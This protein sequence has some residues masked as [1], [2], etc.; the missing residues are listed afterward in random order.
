[1]FDLK[2]FIWDAEFKHWKKI[3]SISDDSFNV[4]IDEVG[5]E[6]S[7]EEIEIIKLAYRL[8]KLKAEF[9]KKYV[10]KELIDLYNESWNEDEKKLSREDF[11]KAIKIESIYLNLDGKIEVYINDNDL[12][13]GKVIFAEIDEEGNFC[14]LD[15]Q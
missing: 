2:D 6:I 11:E 15:L 1:M 4:L 3:E 5:K 14:K 12:F 9:I 13:Q 8:Y 10:A 7:V